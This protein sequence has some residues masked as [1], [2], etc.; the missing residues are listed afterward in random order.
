M[1]LARKV[2]IEAEDPYGR[3]DTLRP[4]H[5]RKFAQF[6]EEW[7]RSC[8]RAF[9]TAMRDEERRRRLELRITS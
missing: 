3:H 6:S 8:N 4:A 7:Y 5:S 1:R 2:A 9:V